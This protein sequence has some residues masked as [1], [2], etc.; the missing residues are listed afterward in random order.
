MT[1]LNC[2]KK[3]QFITSLRNPHGSWKVGAEKQQYPDRFGTAQLHKLQLKICLGL[4]SFINF[5]TE[6][7][8]L[9]VDEVNS[10]V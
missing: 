6:Q 7:L 10:F 4:L 9:R 2:L 5:T 3:I 1:K 8:R